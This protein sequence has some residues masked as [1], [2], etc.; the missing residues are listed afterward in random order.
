MD[1]RATW[2]LLGVLAATYVALMLFFTVIYR[3]GP[4]I[5]ALAMLEMLAMLA[6]AG[7]VAWATGRKR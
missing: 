4:G 7:G 3:G 2:R 6:L 5:G 1:R